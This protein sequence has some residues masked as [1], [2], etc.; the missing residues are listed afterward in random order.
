MAAKKLGWKIYGLD[1]YETENGQEWAVGT[2]AQADRAARENILDSLWAFNASFIAGLVGLTSEEE[3]A[4]KDFQEKLSEGA[5]SIVR[6]II[7]ERNINQLVKV[8]IKADG[9]G[10]FLSSYDSEEHDSNEIE[11]LPKGKLAY[12]IN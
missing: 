4:L 3:K 1:V 10:H 5:N 9:R 6:R 8:A 11:G 2:A 12:R 7:G